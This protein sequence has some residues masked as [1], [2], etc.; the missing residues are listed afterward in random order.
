[1][2]AITLEAIQEHYLLATCMLLLAYLVGSI[3]SAILVCRIFGL[4]D[5]RSEGS[6][7]PG[8]TNVM[9]LGGKG[10]AALTL[11]GDVL[12]GVVPVLAS[13]QLGLPGFIVAWVGF[14]GFLGHLYP[15]FFAF[16]GG[17]GVATA[18]GV[19]FPLYWPAGI[20]TGLTWLLVFGIFRISSL[21][22]LS[23]FTLM[24]VVIFLQIPEALPAMLLM[25]VVMV[26]KHHQNIRNLLNGKELGFKKQPEDGSNNDDG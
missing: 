16:K 2:D 21:A 25:S 24:P 3:S 4:P 7:N 9:R 8:A 18:F 14:A 26:A 17:K 5:P 10:A 23:A 11:I 6:Q 13:W 12:K 1:M 19:L 20:S 22:S 15:V